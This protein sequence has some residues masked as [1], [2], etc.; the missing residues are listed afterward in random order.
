MNYKE[1][2]VN[3]STYRRCN[4]ISIENP[5][6]KVGKIFFGEEDV[7]VTTTGR[8]TVTVAGCS[9]PV[10]MA[11]VL[12][13]YDPNTGLPVGKTITQAEAYS[14]L[15]SV[16]MNAAKLRDEDADKTELSQE[17]IYAI[18]RAEAERQTNGG[19]P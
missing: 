6:D 3:G 15:Y 9:M 19:T 18:K 1:T 11:G 13:L 8:S 14:M 10:N 2:Q 4:H 12:E 16:Y 7:V 17:E 5:L